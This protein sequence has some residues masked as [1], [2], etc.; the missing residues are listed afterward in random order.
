MSVAGIARVGTALWL[1]MLGVA[2]HG[3]TISGTVVPGAMSVAAYDGAGNLA[4]GG[5]AASDGRYALTLPAGVYRVLAFDP[6]GLYATSFYPDAESFETSG[7]LDV[8]VSVGSINM[9][10]AR[11]GYVAGSVSSASGARAA[12]TVAAYNPSGTR[13]G[14]TQTDTAGRYRLTL[15]PGTYKLAAYDEARRWAT[16]FYAG[17]TAFERATGVTVERE[18]TKSADFVLSLAGFI[19]GVV[20]DASTNAPLAGIRASAWDAGGLVISSARSDS[21]GRYEL[22]LPAGSYRLVFDDAVDGVYASV[23]GAG[24]E[25]FD[26]SAPVSV[27]EEQS[28]AFDVS[29]ARGG[30][31]DGTLRDGLT[32]MPLAGLEVAAFNESGTTR[33][34]GRTAANGTFSLLVPPGSFRIGGFDTSLDYATAF[35]PGQML[36]ACAIPVP[37]TSGSTAGGLD[38]ALRRGGR[39]AGT[40]LD[41]RTALPVEG[42]TLGAFDADGALVA[43]CIS[44]SDGFCRLVA[45]PGAYR[46]VVFDPALRYVS[47]DAGIVTVAVGEELSLGA[48]TVFEGAR[49]DG[50][51]RA[52]TSGSPVDGIIVVAYD[53]AGVE[54]VAT[55]TGACGEFGMVVP[56]GTYQFAAADPRKRYVASFYRNAPSID[57]AARITVVTGTRFSA[58]FALASAAQ[59]RRRPV[60][61]GPCA[62]LGELIDRE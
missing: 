6:A 21:T 12:I 43:S 13:R 59:L 34:Q 14:F 44:G 16:A 24:A 55:V 29:M 28:V 19:S 25:S 52:V 38:L 45:P 48:I 46:A 5:V 36:F 56:S 49:I 10:L 41:G 7:L 39:I 51:V 30:R 47:F 11:A 4:A 31:I 40:S 23:Y 15:P 53:L 37:I 35:H 27:S 61:R 54:V 1:G 3:A 60:R 42:M 57:E 8:Q 17:E 22:A 18:V 20:R 62:P 33:T 32:G 2:T 9:T 26:R 58:D 50:T